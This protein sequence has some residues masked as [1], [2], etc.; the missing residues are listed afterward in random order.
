MSI[1]NYSL[2]V[3][4]IIFIIW[5]A[6]ERKKSDKAA[7]KQQSDFWARESEAN[8]ARRKNLDNLAYITIPYDSFPIG[9]YHDDTIT[10]AEQSLLELKDKRILNL[11]GK[12]STDLKLE[13]G[14]ANLTSLDEYDENFVTMV[15]ALQQ[16]AEAMHQAGH[17][18]E[19]KTVLEFAVD[20]GS[21]IKATYTLLAGIYVNEGSAN[22]ITELIT[23]AEALDS[24][25]KNAIIKALQELV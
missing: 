17:F 5:F 11:T 1:F 9:K 19:S 16:Y 25:M 18:S 12:T 10:D 21:D 20:S 8:F 24:L 4:F 3:C 23:K 15:K 7:V 22:K 13:Y 2:S 6:Y 14:V